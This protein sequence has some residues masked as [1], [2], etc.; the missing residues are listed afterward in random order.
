M[1]V[2]MCLQFK[3]VHCRGKEFPLVDRIRYKS[4]PRGHC[5]Q[6]RRRVYTTCV[7]RFGDLKQDSAGLQI[8][9][10]KTY[11]VNVVDVVLGFAEVPCKDPSFDFVVICFHTVLH[12]YSCPHTG[13]S[14]RKAITDMSRLL[15]FHYY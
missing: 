8:S 12:I 10:L 15:F 4:Q 6:S 11:E 2:V 1:Y 9:D 7:W 5:G 13:D 3:Q 14:L